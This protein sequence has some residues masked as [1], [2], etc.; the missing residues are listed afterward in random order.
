VFFTDN[1]EEIEDIWEDR[2]STKPS[3]IIIRFLKKL[4]S[5]WMAKRRAKKLLKNFPEY[6]HPIKYPNS[7]EI[8]NWISEICQTPHRRPG[9][10]EGHQAEKWVA[11]KFKELGLQ[12]ITV[13][14]IP[15]KIW[16]ADRWSLTIGGQKIPSFFILN[17][18]F[19]SNDGI[20]APLAYVGE[21]KKKDFKSVD[22]EGKIVVADV[23]FPYISIGRLIKALKIVG[24]TYIV[25]DPARQITSKTGQYLN[26]VRQNFIGGSTVDNA[27]S[28]D[29]YWQAF[30]Q[31]AKGICLILKNQ[32]S[33][34]NSH[35]GPYD[36]IMKPMPGLWVGKFDGE[37]LREKAKEGANATLKLEGTVKPGNMSNIWG[38]LPGM[39][40]EIVL[41]TSHHDAPFQG[42]VEDGSGVA[43]VLAQVKIWASIPKEKRARTI[44]FVVDAGHFYGSQGAFK[45]AKQHPDL[46]QKTKILI[47]LE[48]LGGIEVQEQD[49]EYVKTDNLALTVMFTSNKPLTI[50]TA[51]N[52]L[53]KKPSK[54]TLPIP[55]DLIA[56]APTSD[57]AGYVV[58]SGVPVISWI[59]CPYYLLDEHD[60]LDK[61]VKEELGSICETVTEMV[62]PFMCENPL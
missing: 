46:M 15:I 20:T 61:I 23:P 62:K 32:P 27:P 35:Y 10:A 39:S 9:T 17:T 16:N 12:D 53:R 24:A 55:S 14:P 22:V 51:V 49:R 21:G 3:G 44:V 8:Y 1:A 41:I 59:G 60:T 6:N 18:G 37:D 38:V 57:A 2:V 42:A 45:F 5:I 56:T 13:D 43:Q 36:G 25:S 29:V 4:P 19:T 28:N 40:E 47:T 34:S 7:T 52:A 31:G 48:H 33:N 26:F 11:S 30:K 54:I 50:A 58:A